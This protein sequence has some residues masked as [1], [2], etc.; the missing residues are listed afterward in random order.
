[1]L[2]INESFDIDLENL[3]SERISSFEPNTTRNIT[4]GSR[5]LDFA[6][7]QSEFAEDWANGSSSPTKNG[8]HIDKK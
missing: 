3:E 2:R 6:S 7:A 4:R 1:M 5:L 8:K